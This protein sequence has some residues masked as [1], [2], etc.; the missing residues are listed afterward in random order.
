MTDMYHMSVPDTAIDNAYAAVSTTAL[1]QHE[2]AGN[3]ANHARPYTCRATPHYQWRGSH[4]LDA[5]AYAHL[6]FP[7]TVATIHSCRLQHHFVTAPRTRNQGDQPYCLSME[8]T[9]RTNSTS[10]ARLPR[11]TAIRRYFLSSNRSS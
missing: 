3:I 1:V 2:H 10:Y 6:P 4:R 7:R 9:C 5:D 8:D 11:S